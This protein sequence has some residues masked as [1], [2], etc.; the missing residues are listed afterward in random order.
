MA[1]TPTHATTSSTAPAVSVGAVMHH[2]MISIPPQSTLEEAAGEMARHCVHCVVVDGLARGADRGEHL[3]W[4]ILSDLD[5]MRAAAAGRLDV[6]AGELAA[7]E[8]ITVDPDD[9]IER[10][11]QLMAEHDIT[12][13]VVVAP[14]T[15][16]PAGVVSSLDVAGALAR[17]YGTGPERE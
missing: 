6:A 5:L 10:V 11:V 2:G 12:H 16:Q 1:T 13:V 4:G 8:I 3:V 17:E 9:T 15:G 7:S 14:D